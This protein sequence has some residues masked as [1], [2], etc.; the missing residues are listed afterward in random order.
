MTLGIPR[1]REI[2]MTASR[3]LKT[4]TMSVPLRASVNDRAALRMTRDFSKLALMDLLASKCGITV[5]EVLEKGPSSWERC[6]Y[7][8]LKLHPAERI[9]EAFGL[10]PDDICRVVSKTF[11]PKLARV[12][13]A[14]MK[15]NESPGDSAKIEVLGGSSSDY[16]ESDAKKTKKKPKDEEYDDEEA[17]AEDGVNASRYGHKKEMTSYGDM[18]DDEKKIAK[19][20]AKEMEDEDEEDSPAVVTEGEESG[21]EYESRSANTCRFSTSKNALILDPLRVDPSTCPL[22]MVGL[23]ER[24]A[25]DTIVKAKPKIKEGFVN[26]EEGRGRCLQTAGCNFE[27]IWQLEEDVVDHNK[28]VSNDIWAIRCAYGV[29]AARMSI[30]DQIRGVFAVYG[31]S[32]DPR[33]L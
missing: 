7:V 8:T 19:S 26:N 25:E 29:E 22:L 18:D 1:L 6:Y 31:I 30:A 28:L 13:K 2:I 33:H 10:Q 9:E 15:R 21:D 32:V 5:R 16:V 20:S 12:M 24:A 11:I 17:D 14:E 27:Q 4:P 23:V 3:E